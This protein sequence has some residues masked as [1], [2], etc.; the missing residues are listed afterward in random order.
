MIFG[1]RSLKNSAELLILQPLFIVI[2]DPIF[3]KFIP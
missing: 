1:K 3:K 2:S